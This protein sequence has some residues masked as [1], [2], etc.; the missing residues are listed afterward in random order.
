MT[1]L[2]CGVV[3]VSAVVVQH[4]IVSKSKIFCGWRVNVTYLNLSL[5]TWNVCRVSL[6]TWWQMNNPNFVTWQKLGSSLSGHEFVLEFFSTFCWTIILGSTQLPLKTAT[7][8]I[9]ISQKRSVYNVLNRSLWL[10]AFTSTVRFLNLSSDRV[11]VWRRNLRQI[12]EEK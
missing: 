1:L 11:S 12:K 10:L 7:I 6:N 8:I 3:V 4:P 9:L 5:S 2:P